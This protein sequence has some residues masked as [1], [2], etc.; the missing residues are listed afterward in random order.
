MTF[1]VG[2]ATGVLAGL[3]GSMTEIR[4]L[5]CSVAE[6]GICGVSPPIEKLTLG[7]GA[8]VDAE[9]M[10]PMLRLSLTFL[11]GGSGAGRATGAM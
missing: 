7:E 3:T 5:G 11:V 6:P 8:A 1:G 2:V 10:L 4:R 9:G